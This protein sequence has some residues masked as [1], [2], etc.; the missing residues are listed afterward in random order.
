MYKTFDEIISQ[1]RKYSFSDKIAFLFNN[2]LEISSVTGID[3]HRDNE[4]YPWELEFL[5]ELSL[6]AIEDSNCEPIN[7]QEMAKIVTFIRNYRHSHF[8]EI[9]GTFISD[10]IVA[11]NPV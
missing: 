3:L 10:I 1:L 6:F 11:A 7:T 4:I 8:R 9:S 2:A 5:V